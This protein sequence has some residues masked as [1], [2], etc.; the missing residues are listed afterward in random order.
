MNKGTPPPTHLASLL[1]WHVVSVLPLLLLLG[2]RLLVFLGQVHQNA[3][4]FQLLAL[5]LR[6]PVR[7]EEVLFVSDLRLQ[8]LHFL[9]LALLEV[10][11]TRTFPQLWELRERERES[12]RER[13]R[14]YSV[15]GLTPPGQHVF[16]KDR[17]TIFLWS[18]ST[19]FSLF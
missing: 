6:H 13:V 14:V 17:L 19:I 1:L 5:A 9:C 18:S 11:P 15:D 7:G 12:E 16:I 2:P 10:V 4:V 8:V 3:L